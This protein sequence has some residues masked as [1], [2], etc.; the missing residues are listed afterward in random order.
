MSVEPPEEAVAV[1]MTSGTTRPDRRGRNFH[2]SL[3]VWEASMRTGFRR[4]VLPESAVPGGRMTMFVLSPGDDEMPNS[5]L[6]HYFTV[7][8]QTFGR[9]DSRFFFRAGRL[10]VD[11]FLD[12]VAAAHAAAQPVMVLGATFAYAHV[13]DALRAR[14]VRAVLPPGSLVFDTGGMKGHGRELRREAFHAWMA[15]WFG[16]TADRCINMYGMT[17][18]SSQLYDQTLCTNGTVR[19]KTGPAWVRTLI[20]HPDTLVPL[21][22]GETGVIAHYDLAN[23]NAAVAI[24]T[25]DLGVRTPHG[26]ELIGRIAGSEARGCSAAIDEVLQAAR[27]TAGDVRG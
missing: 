7:A 25:E 26:F 12:A 15:E 11:A 5:S 13:V 10:D 22:E 21:P 9:A 4:F 3:A 2:P 24:L 1:F 8:V 6:A 20:L 23:W 27:E 19:D 17:E 18:L 14:G 16:V